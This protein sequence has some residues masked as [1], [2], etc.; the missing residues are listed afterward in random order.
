[1]AP[2]ALQ[3]GVE[4]M[5]LQRESIFLCGCMLQSVCSLLM[6][7]TSV[8]L[9]RFSR[10]RT[11]WGKQA[12]VQEEAAANERK[13]SPSADEAHARE[14]CTTLHELK[15]F[16]LTIAFCY[17]ALSL[18]RVAIVKLRGW[19][20]ERGVDKVGPKANA[21]GGLHDGPFVAVHT[22]TQQLRSER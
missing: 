3:P 14:S 10:R 9:V 17:S 8:L 6:C 11:P 19:R 18:K 4:S 16:R 21:L 22:I 12:T 15:F 20:S 2:Q 5:D 7:L 13:F 1:V